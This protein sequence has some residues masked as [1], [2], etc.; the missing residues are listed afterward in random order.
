MFTFR[1]VLGV[2]A[3]THEL[4]GGHNSAHNTEEGAFKLGLE[5]KVGFSQVKGWVEGD[6]SVPKVHIY[7]FIRA[8]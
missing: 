3:S 5:A 4:Q 6:H 1:V 7:L 2:R 8:S